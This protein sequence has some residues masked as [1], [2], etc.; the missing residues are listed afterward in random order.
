MDS[1]IK[2]NVSL[3]FMEMVEKIMV[4]KFGETIVDFA[5]NPRNYHRIEDA[6]GYISY[7]GPCGD[8][9]KIWIRIKGDFIE[10]I[11]FHTNGCEFTKA[12]G[13]MLT[14]LVKGKEIREALNIT[15]SQIETELGGL[16]EDHKHCALLAKD[17][18]HKA[19]ENYYSNK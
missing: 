17:S 9:M 19:V 1:N 6:N 8:T 3:S 18:L 4:E 7:T 14:V 15:S 2:D 10:D 11:G 13:S 16:P 5:N 12:A